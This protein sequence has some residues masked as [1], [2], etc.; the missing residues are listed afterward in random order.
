[1]L[2]RWPTTPSKGE[3]VVG[4]CLRDVID[5]PLKPIFRWPTTN[6]GGERVIGHSLKGYSSTPW[7]II[8][9]C[10]SLFLMLS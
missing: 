4:H 3:E 7:L 1:M 5:H 9:F 10:F 2:L 6:L 8:V